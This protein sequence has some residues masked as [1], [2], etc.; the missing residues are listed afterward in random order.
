LNSS[1]LRTPELEE[2][3]KK[4]EKRHLEYIRHFENKNHQ[5]GKNG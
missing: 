4:S 5:T 1:H 2:K 3:H